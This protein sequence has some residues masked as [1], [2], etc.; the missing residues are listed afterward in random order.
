MSESRPSEKQSSGERRR[1]VMVLLW[2]R[3]AAMFPQWES[4]YGDVDDPAISGWTKNLEGF[5]EQELGGAIKSCER[6]EGKFPPSY[7]EFRRQCMNARNEAK[8][9]VYDQRI[10]REKAAGQPISM[11]EHLSRVATSPTAKR[12]LARVMR[13]LAG[14]DVETKEQSMHNL[15]LYARWSA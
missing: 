14:E 9:T 7:P 12:E 10:A 1:R 11:I 6:W 4:L 15:N 5:T 13:L 2:A 3:M 8:P